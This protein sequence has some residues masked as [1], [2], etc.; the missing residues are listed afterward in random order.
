MAIKDPIIIPQLPP[1][2]TFI[3]PSTVVE[4]PSDDPIGTSYL[5]TPIYSNLILSDDAEELPD[6]VMD[7]I[8]MIVTQFR[9]I[10]ETPLAG[11]DGTVKEYI[12]DGDFQVEIRGVIISPYKNQYP[13]DQVV[14]LKRYCSL[15]KEISVSSN[16]LDIFDITTAVVMSY[17][18]GEKVGSR[19]E[20]PFTLRLLSDEPIEIKV[21]A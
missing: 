8:L 19:N 11:R 21:N 7:S 17:D 3:R 18:V 1:A 15:K 12:S 4:E 5:G 10:V 6:L 13:R 20:V 2:G 14:L 16:F 9:N